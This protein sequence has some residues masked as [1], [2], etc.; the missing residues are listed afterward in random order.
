MDIDGKVE[1]RISSNNYVIMVGW[2]YERLLKLKGASARAHNFAYISHDD[3]DTLSS[4]FLWHARYGNINYDSLCL[5]KKN[6]VFD[7]P[8]IPRNLK[9]CDACILGKR[10]KQPFHDFTLRVCRKLE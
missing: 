4:S 6:G 9:Q 5:L 2:E 3:E 8:L 1:I 7:L 10:N